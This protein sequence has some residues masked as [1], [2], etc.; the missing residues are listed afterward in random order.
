MA[1]EDVAMS[2]HA[3]AIGPIGRSSRSRFPSALRHAA[4]LLAVGGVVVLLEARMLDLDHGTHLLVILTVVVGIA[5]LLGPGPATTGFAAGGGL[6]AAASVITGQGVIGTPPVY[7][8]LSMYLLAGTAFI[9]LMNVTRRARRQ[10]AKPL[11]G[12]SHVDRTGDGPTDSLT[13]RELEVLRLAA[14]GISVEEIANRLFVSPNTAKTHLTHIYAKL[15]V[16]G[17]SDA[18]RA[19]LHCGWLTPVDICPHRL[20]DWQAESPVPG[21]ADHRKR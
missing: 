11:A 7:V 16:R 2:I 3:A 5:L 18:V 14:T 15:G 13:A 8:Q 20:A 9:V 10:A 21:T 6:A 17:R 19:G 4:A 12:P 1:C